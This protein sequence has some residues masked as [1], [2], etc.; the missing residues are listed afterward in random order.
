MQLLSLLLLVLSQLVRISVR[1]RGNRRKTPQRCRSR[2]YCRGQCGMGVGPIAR[3]KASGCLLGEAP[4]LLIASIG[5]MRCRNFV[6]FVLTP[7]DT[8]KGGRG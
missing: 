7:R 3:P 8:T 4:L 1:S 6:S 5:S 2:R